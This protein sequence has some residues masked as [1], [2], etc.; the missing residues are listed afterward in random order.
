MGIVNSNYENSTLSIIHF[1]PKVLR[2]NLGNYNNY[3]V[4]Y[5]SLLQGYYERTVRAVEQAS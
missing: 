4:G 3:N 2:Q 1:K 5:T